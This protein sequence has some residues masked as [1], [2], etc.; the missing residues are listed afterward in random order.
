[1]SKKPEF[2][3]VN[4]FCGF[5]KISVFVVISEQLEDDT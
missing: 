3:N 4:Q 2:I 1:M 5:F